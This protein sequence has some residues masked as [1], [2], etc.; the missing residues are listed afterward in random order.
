MDDLP[1]K[2]LSGFSYIQIIPLVTNN[3][4]LSPRA[5]NTAGY[6]SKTRA[7]LVRQREGWLL[8]RSLKASELQARYPEFILDK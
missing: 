5:G 1:E 7:L 3:N 8:A 2:G 4:D 6:V